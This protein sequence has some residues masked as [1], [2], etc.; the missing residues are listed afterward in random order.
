MLNGRKGCKLLI[1]PMKSI[2]SES[3]DY[4]NFVFKNWLH[5]P[6]NVGMAS[7]EKQRFNLVKDDKSRSAYVI[8][9]VDY[10]CLIFNEI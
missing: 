2:A 6:N 4:F 10:F 7:F 8:K 5:T 9:S 1:S 3:N